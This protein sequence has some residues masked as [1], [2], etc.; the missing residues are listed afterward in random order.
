[1]TDKLEAE[2]RVCLTEENEN[3][4]SRERFGLRLIE[5]TGFQA[6][7]RHLTSSRPQQTRW[8]RFIPGR[9]YAPTHGRTRQKHNA[10]EGAAKAQKFGSD[11]TY[12]FGDMR[13]N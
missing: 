4:G 11:R 8:K 12:I 1:M 13:A 6:A 9:T 7:P 5:S 10:I 3:S 2:C